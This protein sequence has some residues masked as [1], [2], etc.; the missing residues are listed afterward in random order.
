VIDRCPWYIAGP[1]LGLLMV[2]LRATLNKPFGALGGFI[3]LA[4][5]GRAPRLLGFRAY[6]LAGLVL[7]GFIHAAVLGSWSSPSSYASAFGLPVSDT[8]AQAAVL[9]AAGIMMGFGARTAGG[10]TSGHGMSGM[11]LA[12]PASITASMTFFSVA[13]AVA[14]MIAWLGGA[15]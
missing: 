14:H 2:G 10:C 4:E 8:E 3:E 6:L 13:V 5:S 12:S 7:G 9:F 1:L 11:S 15:P